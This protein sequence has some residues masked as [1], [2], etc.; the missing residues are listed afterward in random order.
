MA[1]FD[2]PAQN[3]ADPA[4]TEFEIGAR[5]VDEIVTVLKSGVHPVRLKLLVECF[6]GDH[7]NICPFHSPINKQSGCSKTIYEAVAPYHVVDFKMMTP[8][9]RRFLWIGCRT[10][11]GATEAEFPYPDKLAILDRMA[12]DMSRTQPPTPVET[13]TLP[14]QTLMPNQT[15]PPHQP[16]LSK[17]WQ[18]Y[19]APIIAAGI[20]VIVVLLLAGN[21]IDELSLQPS[22]NYPAAYIPAFPAPNTAHE[23]R[24]S[25]R[26]TIKPQA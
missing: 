4:N 13:P 17:L 19:P 1:A 6:Q 21:V 7:F 25:I 2:N 26:Q 15:I 23:P 9:V 11:F 16:T 14:P 24:Q 5:L 20:I 3:N 8:D 22:N 10:A 12:D 18:R